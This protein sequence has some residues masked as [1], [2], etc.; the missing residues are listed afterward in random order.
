MNQRKVYELVENFKAERS[1]R[2]RSLSGRA[3]ISR[4]EAYIQMMDALNREDQ[5]IAIEQKAKIMVIRYKSA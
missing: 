4:E 1:V 5:Q 2:D 3:S